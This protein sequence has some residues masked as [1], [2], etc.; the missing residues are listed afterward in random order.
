LTCQGVDLVRKIAT[1]IDRRPFR[2]ES[3]RL[4]LIQIAV[5]TTWTLG[6]LVASVI[7]FLPRLQGHRWLAGF[8]VCCIGLPL[9][10]IFKNFL[11]GV[12]LPFRLHDQIIVNEFEGPVEAI[13]IWATLR[14]YQGGWVLIPNAIV[15]T[16]AVQILMPHRR[17]DLA[18]GITILHYQR[19]SLCYSK[20]C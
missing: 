14:T 10:G 18:V 8:G 6:I 16:S 9:Q 17:T 2:R 1:A 7:A 3:L 13:N 20:P 4:L 11:V 5:I 15:F 19:R 12:L